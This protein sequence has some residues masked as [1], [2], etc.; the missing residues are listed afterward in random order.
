MGENIKRYRG[1]QNLSQELLARKTDLKLSNL[2]KLESGLNSN[3]TLATLAAIAR[4]LTK[5]SID[6][7]VK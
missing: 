4:I 5:G 2:A 1:R 6:R 7:L 3:P